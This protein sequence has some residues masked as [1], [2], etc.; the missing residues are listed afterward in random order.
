LPNKIP[1][2]NHL[3]NVSLTLVLLTEQPSNHPSQLGV[4]HHQAGVWVQV[5]D[6]PGW[7][8]HDP[9]GSS[10][11]GEE[12]G[13]GGFVRHRHD[14]EK[15]RVSLSLQKWPPENDERSPWGRRLGL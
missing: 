9:D 1:P 15:P 6:N 5:W 8:H 14:P 2:T 4:C 7:R 10:P 11:G 3:K 13:G 12:E